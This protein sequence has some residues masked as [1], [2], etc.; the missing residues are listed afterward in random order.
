MAQGT[1]LKPGQ[2][3]PA[4]GIYDVI[5]PHGGKTGH[6]VTSVVGHP[7]PPT[8]RP[9]QVYVPADLANGGRP[10]PGK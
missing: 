5:G 10:R 7:M 3:T 8:E 2:E 9:G 4:S 6:Q 1:P